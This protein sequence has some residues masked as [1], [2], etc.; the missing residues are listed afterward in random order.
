LHLPRC[1]A[2]AKLLYPP[3]P[4]CPHCLGTQFDWQ[5]LSGRGHIVAWTEVH[6]GT[7]P[8]IAPPFLLAEVA[9]DEQSDVIMTALLETRER[10][11]PRVGDAVEM[12]V[13]PPD[14]AGSVYPQFRARD[15]GAQ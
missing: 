7:L 4:R 12:R 10:A 13:T 15:G 5:R 8:G 1:I 6:L 11:P 14:A 3:P 9:L 2:C